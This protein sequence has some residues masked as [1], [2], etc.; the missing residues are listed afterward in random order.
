MD[1]KK[2]Q[3]NHN[4]ISQNCEST[5]V[6]GGCRSGKSR[7]AL[8]LA[9]KIAKDKKLFIATSVP[10]DKEM[11]ERVKIHQ[12]DRGADWETA[13]IPIA[14]P[15]KI[16]DASKSYDVILVDCLTLWVSNLLFHNFTQPEIANITKKLENAVQQALCPVIFVTN[17][18]GAGIVPENKLARLFRDTAGF[19]NQKIAA[20][21]DNV[22]LMAAGIPLK[23]KPG[24]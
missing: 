16:A 23:I 18:V 17:E 10:T 14:I 8:E 4:S 15:E 13:E 1:T 20:A 12:K 22:F 11:E 6:I 9:N 19:V 2:T 5:L 24:N 21:A 7:Y 3:N